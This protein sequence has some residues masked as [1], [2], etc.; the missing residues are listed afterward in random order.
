MKQ[1]GQVWWWGNQKVLSNARL[2]EID[3]IG[4]LMHACMHGMGGLAAHILIYDCY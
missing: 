3:L 4:G 1:K 2:I